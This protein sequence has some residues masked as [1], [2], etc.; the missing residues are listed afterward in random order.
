MKRWVLFHC[1]GFFAL[2]FVVDLFAALAGGARRSAV[3]PET[4]AYAVPLERNF[5]SPPDSAKPWCYWWWLNGNVTEES[6]KRDLREM[7]AKG[8]SG[9][10]LFD[11]RG[12][13]DDHLPPPPPRMEFM[14]DEWRRMVKLAITE[15]DRL[16]LQISINLSSCA[17]ALKG[18]WEVGDDT[19]K[20]LVWVSK[21]IVG[22]SR[23]EIELP[24]GQWGKRVWDVA[25]IAAR[26]AEPVD[27][28]KNS[29]PSTLSSSPISSTVIEVV[30]LSTKVSPEGRLSWDVPGG[31]WTLLRF[32]A[33]PMEGHEYD[34]DVLSRKA[35]AAHFNRMGRA[36]LDDAG[37]LARKVLS[38]FY[39]VSWEGAAP[40]WSLGFEE[41]FQRRRG[42]SLRPYLPILAGM[43]LQSTPTTLS[44]ASIS[45]R[46][47]R[48]YHKTL[49]DCF[50]DNF[51]GTLRD[52]CRENGLQ[53]HSESGG[54]WNR[55]LPDFEHADQLA[56]LGRNDMPQ[57]EFW[58]AGMGADRWVPARAFNRPVAMAAHIYG[59]PLAA[60][61]AFTN[62]VR[63]WS[64]C[65]ATLKPEADAAFCDG[66]NH[67][68]WH[69]FSASPPEFGKPGIEYFAGTH[70][71][72]NVTWW[73]QAGAFLTYLARCQLML[74]QGT[75][76]A[77]VCVYTGDKPYLHWGRG[78]T[79]SAKPTL[80]LPK[81]YA[82]DLLSTEV[83]LERLSVKNGVLVLPDGMTYRMLVVDL[84]DETALPEALR[85][86]ANLTRNGATVVLG[87][88]RPERAPGLTNFPACDEEVRRLA[89]ELWGPADANLS[90]R[91]FGKGRIF[92]GMAMEEVLRAQHIPPDFEGPFQYIHRRA[93]DMDIYFVSGTG[94]A[95]C[96]FRINGK[97]PELWDPN[98]NVEPNI[99]EAVK[100]CSTDDGRTL[101]P[102]DLPTSGSVFVV[103]RNPVRLPSLTTLSSPL[104]AVEIVGRTQNGVRL[105]LW[106]NGRHRLETSQGKQIEVA[107]DN[108]PAPRNL[109][110]AWEVRF[111]SGWGA[112]EK[113]VF[114][115]LVPWNEHSHENIKYF[116]GT[117]SYRKTVALDATQAKHLVR[118]NLGE[119][120]HIA[121]VKVNGLSCGTVWTAPWIAD[122]T[123]K[124]RPGKNELEIT[125]TNLWVNRLIGD[126][127]LPPEKRFTRTNATG[128]DE[129][130][131]A[132]YAHL[133][134][135]AP[136]DPLERS[137][138]MGPVSLAFG[139][140][141]DVEF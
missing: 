113:T 128:R 35:V 98:T 23:S 29:A 83:L 86:I 13:H 81:G 59:R 94:P 122:L 134:G 15:A 111:A 30:D 102:I 39:S 139:E 37:P 75:F 40:T 82:Y 50:M 27:I 141:R 25:V 137:G 17:G 101:V 76:V 2:L 57:G 129:S 18:P 69:T 12:Y 130:A 115:R 6:I 51:Y 125:V 136:T 107:V 79:W 38:H 36:L 103:F 60:A 116:S 119:V 126:T 71:N 34:V 26:H 16:G 61:E 127:R 96:T 73:E 47:L 90:R 3:S 131:G 48:D 120:R 33:I 65:P 53:W 11:A 93:E 66:I 89:A 78:E 74:R 5:L 99:R 22:P 114:D 64:E 54:P 135:Y 1:F 95:H 104:D 46:F 140:V 92:A 62:M 70:L 106:K 58:H 52:L 9:C 100:Y 45:S 14:S 118:L 20:K 44:M 124:V 109:E 42:Y 85:K 97:E 32:A 56:F 117:A 121:E 108:L 67:F 63:H 133:R 21:D 8:F 87:Y 123:G 28:Q 24:R 49:G 112:P 55:K 31:R 132:P 19:P 77:D 7:K 4:G 43:T 110:G 80:T 68:I 138:L 72:P 105:R 41:E 91:D 10:L 84:E 88:R